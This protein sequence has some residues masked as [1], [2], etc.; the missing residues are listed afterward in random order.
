MTAASGGG[1]TPVRHKCG[2]DDR[3]CRFERWTLVS[4]PSLSLAGNQLFAAS[5]GF[6]QFN[7]AIA[8]RTDATGEDVSIGFYVGGPSKETATATIVHEVRWGNS[9]DAPWEV[10]GTDDTTFSITTPEYGTTV[11]SPVTVGGRISGVD[12]NIAVEVRISSSSSAVGTFCC[13][14]AGGVASPWHSKVSFVA[15][16]GSVLTIVARTGGHVATVERITVTGARAG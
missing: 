9:S 12:E 2:R 13:L 11:T 15:P 6:P 10:V 4:V 3:L 14:P 1:H 5:L 7:K 8:A 16:T